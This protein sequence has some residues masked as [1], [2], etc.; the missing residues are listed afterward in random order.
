[1]KVCI[2]GGHNHSGYDTGAQGNGLKEQDITWAIS[3]I[4]AEKLGKLGLETVETRPLKTSNVNNSS[5]N[6]S[7][8]R[9]VEICNNAK[10]DLF[11][12]VHCN[13]GG[14]TGTETYVYSKSGKAYNLATAVNNAIINSLPLKD[15]SVKTADFAVLRNTNC[16]A[17]LVETAF[18]DNALDAKLFWERLPDFA[19]AILSGICKYLSIA[20]DEPKKEPTID[21][22]K[23]VITE[24][25][26]YSNPA[27]VFKCFDNHPYKAD[28]I[29]KWYENLR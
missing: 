2:D 5:I 29:R 11:V 14:G 24:K 1:M 16:P 28:L 21:E 3:S 20:I 18:I 23:A 10:C 27:D 13:A 7:L 8:N 4:V 9:R 22:M 15:R 26:G 6:A 12:S 17:I 19:E 25:C